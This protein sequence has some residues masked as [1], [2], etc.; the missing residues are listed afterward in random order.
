MTRFDYA[1]DGI[2]ETLGRLHPARI[3]RK[4]HTPLCALL[5][6]VMI[7]GALVS[8]EHYRVERAVTAVDAAQREVSRSRERLARL[9]LERLHVNQLLQL[10]NRL[11]AI[12]LSGALAGLRLADVANHVPANAW[13]TALSD[14]EDGTA[15]DGDATNLRALSVTIAD[16]MSS[17]S[18]GSPILI[19]AG[20]DKTE[21]GNFLSFQIHGEERRR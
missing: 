2:P 5:T 16:L 3:D 6:A 17:D 7:V 13:L 19:Q 8:I 11:R 12:R 10:D 20:D 15:I 4:W 18:V 21:Y 14:A 1:H 9:N